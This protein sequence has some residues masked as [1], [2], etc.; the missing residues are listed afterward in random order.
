MK[1]KCTDL[2]E[3]LLKGLYRI[4][5]GKPIKIGKTYSGLTVANFPGGLYT[6]EEVIPVLVEDGCLLLMTADRLKYIFLDEYYAAYENHIYASRA[7]VSVSI[8]EPLTY[9]TI[10][11]FHNRYVRVPRVWCALIVKSLDWES[12]ES[13]STI[14]RMEG[15]SR[16]ALKTKKE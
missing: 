8:S 3:N 16:N 14:N 11:D 15:F 1:V 7:S 4:I 12:I 5:S 13:C 2:T 10:E 6:D 9:E